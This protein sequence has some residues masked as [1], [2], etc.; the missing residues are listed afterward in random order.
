MTEK[1]DKLRDLIAAILSKAGK[2]AKVKLARLVLFAEI[3]HFK[4]TRTSITGLY[5]IRLQIGPVI[6]FFDEVLEEG[7]SS[8]WDKKITFIYMEKYKTQ[9][10]IP[11]RDFYLPDDMQRTVD[12]VVDTYGEKTA[13]EL[14]VLSHRLPAWLY[15]D[16]D[17]VIH[18]A[19]LALDTE[20]E[21]FAMLDMLEE[22][23]TYDELLEEEV[24]RVLYK[25]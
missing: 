20:E 15:S 9:E 11:L 22:D 10:Y 23:D 6:A 5:F 1:K 3:E 16:P 7:I 21:Y 2:T 14:S 4:R 24:S 18:T 25:S 13:T 8:L 19:E 12:S 17:N